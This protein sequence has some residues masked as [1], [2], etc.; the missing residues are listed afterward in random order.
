MF[1][2]IR[3]TAVVPHDPAWAAMFQASAAEIAAVL[4]PEL[5]AIHHAGSTAI[6]GIRAK[7]IIDIVV[8]ARQ[9]SALDSHTAALSA[10]GYEARGEFGIAGRR[11]FTRSSNGQRTHNVHCFQTGHPEIERML[12]LRDYLLAHPDEARTYSRLKED[13]SRQFPSD[14]DRYTDGKSAFVETIVRRAHVWRAA[15]RAPR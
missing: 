4:G 1:Q 5:L 7:P 9:L 11:F 2:P 14:I 13:L 15:G 10:L 12:N 3:S 6:P 8:E